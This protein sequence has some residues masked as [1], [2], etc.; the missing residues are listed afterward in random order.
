[1]I[2]IAFV[3]FIIVLN[4]TL[5]LIDAALFKKFVRHIVRYDLL[6]LLICLLVI[7][8]QT[9]PAANYITS[10]SGKEYTIATCIPKTHLYM[11]RAY[12]FT[13]IP[14]ELQDAVLIETS[15][16]DKTS[17]QDNLFS[18]NVKDGKGAKIYF[19]LDSRVFPG[20]PLRSFNKRTEIVLSSPLVTT[21]KQA[22][23]VVYEQDVPASDVDF[24]FAGNLFWAPPQKNNLA[25]FSM[26]LVMI[27]GVS[28]EQITNANNE[29]TGLNSSGLL[30]KPKDSTHFREQV[31]KHGDW[32]KT[33]LNNSERLDLSGKKI[34]GVYCYNADLQNADLEHTICDSVGFYSSVLKEIEY[35]NAKLSRVNFFNSR[36]DSADFNGASFNNCSFMGAD[37]DHSIFTNVKL[38]NVNFTHANV[39]GMIFEPDSLPDIKGMAYADNLDSITYRTN[40]G[41]LIKL[42]EGFKNAG[43]YDA[44]RKIIAAIQRRK[45]ALDPDWVTRT[46]DYLLF[47]LTSVYGLKPFRPLI[48]FMASIY[49]FYRVY[50]ILFFIGKLNIRIQHPKE[51]VDGHA[52]II[53]DGIHPG[54][55]IFLSIITAFAIGFG[56]FNINDW[57]KKLLKEDYTIQSYGWTRVLI[58]IQNLLS[59]LLVSLTILLLLG[60]PFN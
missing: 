58:G 10:N 59:L 39:A 47:D 54:R 33:G 28:T 4:G 24:Q 41:M 15:N 52:T 53:D 23:Y 44:Q 20:K 6:A 50:L 51:D 27:S 22:K 7:S 43:F 14:H 36:L 56:A 31:I 2:L 12:T 25:N 38:K 19:I 32:L 34:N 26:Y 3:T 16:E 29:E 17:D 46:I 45:Q 30:I 13:K 21:D 55:L 8:Y 42:K 9:D 57:A 18:I 1:M 11:D 60:H 48:I 40:P 37:L 5:L 35:S 49:L